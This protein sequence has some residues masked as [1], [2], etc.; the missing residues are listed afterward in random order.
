[1]IKVLTDLLNS[2]LSTRSKIEALKADG[3]QVTE[4]IEEGVADMCTYTEGQNLLVKTIQ[5]LRDGYTEKELLDQGIDKQT[6]DL[7]MTVK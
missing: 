1:M 6:I 5:L 3:I 2:D 7:A 4:E